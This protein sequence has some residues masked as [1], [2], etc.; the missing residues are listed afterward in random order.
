[1]DPVRNPYAP[2]AGTPPP[3]SAVPLFDC[4]MRRTLLQADWRS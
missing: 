2:G 1:M 4:F 3:E